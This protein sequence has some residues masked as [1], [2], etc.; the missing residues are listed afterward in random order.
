ML[1]WFLLVATVN[2]QSVRSVGDGEFVVRP[3]SAE[4]V[5]QE[6]GIPVAVGLNNPDRAC[7]V[8]VW[9]KDGQLAPKVST[10]CHPGLEWAAEEAAAAWKIDVRKPPAFDSRV[11]EYW[12]VFP[13][14]KG[15]P[16]NVAIRQEWNTV[17]RVRPAW[18]E[19]VPFEVDAML[20]PDYPVAALRTSTD[21][22]RCMVDIDVGAQGEVLR[23]E[24][25]RCDEVFHRTAEQAAKG[26]LIKGALQPDLSLRTGITVGMTFIRNLD[27]RGGTV[28]LDLPS[29]AD[30]GDREVEAPAPYRV[31]PSREEPTGK[32]LV[33]LDHRSYAEVGVYDIVWPQ[34]R[35]SKSD[36]SCDILFQ[37]NSQRQVWAW[38]EE[39]CDPGIRRAVVDAAEQWHLAPG[40]IGENELFARFRGTFL[41]PAGWLRSHDAGTPERH[42]NEA[43]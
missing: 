34:G 29:A 42:R 23:T 19:V 13:R 33:V 12:Y 25:R 6:V 28:Q 27:G 41:F 36:R 40:E 5:V 39:P 17:L 1:S 18:L 38:P 8:E 2:A 22:T 9:W 20:A 37:V 24:A 3:G 43:R 7:R 15:G 4:L 30:I 16:I 14:R 10:D 31:P 35:A 11:F 32:P 21:I 26:W